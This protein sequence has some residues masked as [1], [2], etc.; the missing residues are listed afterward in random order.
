MVIVEQDKSLLLSYN[1]CCTT[2][3]GKERES[4]GTPVNAAIDSY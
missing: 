3:F 2:G 1:K 4:L